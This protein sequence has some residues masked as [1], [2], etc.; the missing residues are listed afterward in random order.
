[1]AVVIRMPARRPSLSRRR[2]S[3]PPRRLP[4]SSRRRS[5]SRRPSLSPLFDR[6]RDRSPGLAAS[7]AAGA[8]AAGLGLAA[9]TVLAIVLWVS[10]PY[11]DSGPGGALHIAVALW[12]LAHGVELIRTDTLSGAP[13]PVGVTP[14]LLLVVPALLLY[15]GTRE[16]V[17]ARDGRAADPPPPVRAGTA[18]TGV[19]AGYLGVGGCA[20]LYASG[21]Q[22]RPAWGWVAVCLPLFA[23]LAAGA[24]V[25]TAYGRPR[26]PVLNLVVTLPRA[27]R[28]L[29]LG[30]DTRVRWGTALRAS[31]AGVTVFFGGGTLLLAV[32]L[33]GHGDATRA[34]FLQL[35]ESWTGRF[36][37]LLLCVSLVPNA[38]VWSASYAVGPGF[39]LGAGHVVSPLASDPAP[40]LPP[41]PLLAAVPAHG[42]GTPVTWLAGLVP[43]AAGVTVAWFVV[44]RAVGRGWPAGRTAGVVALAALLCAVLLAAL[45]ELAGGPLGVSALHRFGPV[46][47]Q[48]GAAAAAWLLGVGVPAALALRAWRTEGAASLAAWLGF[49]KSP[50]AGEWQ[51]PGKPGA[52]PSA[53]ARAKAPAS[54]PAPARGPVVVLPDQGDGYTFEPYEALPPELPDPYEP[55]LPDPPSSPWKDTAARKA[56]WA[57]L[58]K[59]SEPPPE[60]PDGP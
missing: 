13:A 29:L 14:L 11:P 35:T 3:S 49:G 31:L 47:W 33:V 56:R 27:V 53:R 34:S 58:R 40:L 51:A 48:T 52:A 8:L 55:L 54:A 4:L 9:F 26:E 6:V 7:L 57:A 60:G 20:A 46:W 22:L 17:D 43:V 23:G 12:L 44:G 21:G 45:A 28:R 41:F 18:W 36:A 16:A 32:S 15:R 25:W 50:A 2:P 1:M 39:A 19:V 42:P 10:S 37:V 24:G 5:S 30:R 59:M 38:A